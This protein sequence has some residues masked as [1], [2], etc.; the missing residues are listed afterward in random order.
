MH[1]EEQWD[2]G[3]RQV[4]SWQFVLYLYV[5]FTDKRAASFPFMSLCVLQT[6]EL[7]VSL[8]PVLYSVEPIVYVCFTD[9]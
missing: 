9:R 8:M 2:Y 1:A 5:C 4:R 7:S 3:R 6:V